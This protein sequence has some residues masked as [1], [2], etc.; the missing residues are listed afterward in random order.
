[1]IVSDAMPT[2]ETKQAV[3]HSKMEWMMSIINISC[4]SVIATNPQ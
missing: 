1:M 4:G 3:V 2:N